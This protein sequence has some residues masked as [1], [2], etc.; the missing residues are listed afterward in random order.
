M[1]YRNSDDDIR[2]GD[3]VSH[4]IRGLGTVVRIRLDRDDA[5]DIR[6]DNPPTDR[7]GPEGMWLAR[8]PLLTLLE[9]ALSAND[10]NDDRGWL[11]WKY[12]SNGPYHRRI[13]DRRLFCDPT[14]IRADDFLHLISIGPDVFRCPG[15]E[16]AY[17][18]VKEAASK[19][20]S[21]PPT[22]INYDAP[23]PP[24]ER[25]RSGEYAGQARH[26]FAELET[27]PVNLQHLANKRWLKGKVPKIV[28]TGWDPDGLG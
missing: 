6:L 25:Y 14:G 3:R 9:R 19:P 18:A 26:I 8:R 15:C 22:P 7:I 1:N 23:L 21:A 5:V 13:G 24:F 2:V 20:S 27:K 28:S 10:V 11:I 17:A 4:E 12:N 16:T